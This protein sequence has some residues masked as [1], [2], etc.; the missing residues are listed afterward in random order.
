VKSKK[1]TVR[2]Q[3]LNDDLIR[4]GQ[5]VRRRRE[6]QDISQEE[7]ADRAGLHRNYIGYVERAEANATVTSVIKIARALKLRPSELLREMKWSAG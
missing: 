3:I 5:E 7:L 2:K 6:A 1:K 4:F